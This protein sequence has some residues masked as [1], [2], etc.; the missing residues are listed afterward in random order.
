MKENLKK[1]LILWKDIIFHPNKIRGGF[2]IFIFLII[3][4]LVYSIQY[5]ISVNATKTTRLN[6]KIRDLD[7]QLKILK[8]E[9][10]YQTSNPR[11]AHLYDLYLKDD[12]QN[13]N[14]KI[15]IEQLEINS[16]AFE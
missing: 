13:K 12:Y 7:T 4:L 6:A 10:E 11:I 16:K 8:T 2:S 14:R 5:H 1:V 3:F 15:Y 9:F